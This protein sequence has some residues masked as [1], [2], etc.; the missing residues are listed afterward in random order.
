MSATNTRYAKSSNMDY[1]GLD[2]VEENGRGSTE[3]PWPQAT[4]GLSEKRSLLGW[5]SRSSGSLRA[6]PP[7]YPPAPTCCRMPCRS[8][9]SHSST[10]LPPAMRCWRNMLNDI[11]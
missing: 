9:C 4:T 6:G 11:G 5:H 1:W 8:Y 10:I 7:H 2:D 3:P